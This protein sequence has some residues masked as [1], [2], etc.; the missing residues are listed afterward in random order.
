MGVGSADSRAPDRDAIGPCAGGAT[1]PEG[2]AEAGADQSPASGLEPIR[3]SIP[4]PSSS[5]L[6]SSS[7]LGEASSGSPSLACALRCFSSASSASIFF[8]A[9][10]FSSFFFFF[11]FFFFLFFFLSAASRRASLTAAS[12]R[13]GV[14]AVRKPRNPYRRIGVRRE[15]KKP[16]TEIKTKDSPGTHNL[17][18]GA[19][20]RR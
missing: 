6:S 7:I 9:R 1:R 5:S 4:S 8:W 2:P 19:S 3:T 20:A 18:R 17:A 12:S 14:Q 15:G 16:E 11:L 13:T 10:F